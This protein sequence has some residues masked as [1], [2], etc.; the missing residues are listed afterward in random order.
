MAKYNNHT[1][2]ISRDPTANDPVWVLSNIHGGYYR[3]SP[4]DSKWTI[5]MDPRAATRFRKQSAKNIIANC[6][7]KEQAK[8]WIVINESKLNERLTLADVWEQTKETEQDLAISSTETSKNETIKEYIPERFR[9]GTFDWTAYEQDRLAMKR[10]VLEYRQ[11][12]L[13]LE[14][15]NH[16]EEIDLRHKIEL[17]KRPNVVD[18][19]RLLMRYRDNLTLRR[20]IKNDLLRC[21]IML[22]GDD[23]HE[24]GEALSRLQAV[25]NQKY[26]PRAL[27][28][29]FEDEDFIKRKDERK[30]EKMG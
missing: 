11:I 2:S 24:C 19:Y 9:D 3:T 18:G 1:K 30:D 8:N 17:G 15:Q 5:T 16:R 6:L 20:R 26:N 7:P 28:D 13:K 14:V 25:D 21:E 27:Q 10:D 12:L 4:R 23:L 22:L 29:L